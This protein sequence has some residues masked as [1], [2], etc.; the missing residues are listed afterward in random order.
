M[1]HCADTLLASWGRKQKKNVPHPSLPLGYYPDGVRG[2]LGA[3]LLMANWAGSHS[4]SLKPPL[5]RSKYKV[6]LLS[7]R[8]LHFSPELH[9]SLLPTFILQALLLPPLPVVL[10]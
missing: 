2:H 4:V 10:H 9:L 8:E 7:Q 6:P 1:P 5:K 3:P